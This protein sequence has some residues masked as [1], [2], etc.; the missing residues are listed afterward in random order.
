D[1]INNLWPDQINNLWPDQ[2]NNLWPDQINNLWPDQ[3]NLDK[4][5]PSHAVIQLIVDLGV[6]ENMIDQGEPCFEVAKFLERNNLASAKVKQY[7]RE[8]E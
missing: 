6:V 1:Q 4:T 3:I 7:V 2:I 8:L 5:A